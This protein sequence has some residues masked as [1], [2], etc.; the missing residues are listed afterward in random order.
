MASG[1]EDIIHLPHHQSKVHPRMPVSAR[2]AQ[3]APFAALTG[4]EDAVEETARLTE[5]RIELTEE[6]KAMIDL[7]LQYLRD[8]LDEHPE[9][10]VTYFVPDSRK[11]GGT[12]VTVQGNLKSMDQLVGT[13]TLQD[14]TTIPIQEI[15]QLCL[16]SVIS[17]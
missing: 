12:Y 7:K 4:Y 1:Y 10:T 3:F 15:T 16:L 11:A 6:A 13:I 14:R 8:H 17:R 5:E 9:V 2:A